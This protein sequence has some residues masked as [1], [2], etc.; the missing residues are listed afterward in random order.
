MSTA[1]PI[2]EPGESFF[3]YQRGS[4]DS[5]LRGVFLHGR[6]LRKEISDIVAAGKLSQQLVD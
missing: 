2:F 5:G 4:Y 1:G 3:E 6:A